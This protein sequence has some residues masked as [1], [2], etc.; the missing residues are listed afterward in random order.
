MNTYER[1]YLYVRG[2]SF[3][4]FSFCAWIVGQ[5]SPFFLL[6]YGILWKSIYMEMNIL[7]HLKSSNVDVQQRSS[8]LFI[9]NE[10]TIFRC[11]P[12]SVVSGGEKQMKIKRKRKRVRKRRNDRRRFD[13][14][15]IMWT[16]YKY[17]R[18]SV[19]HREESIDI[20]LELFGYN[21]I[22]LWS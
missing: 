3:S 1:I 19:T 9:V 8:Q 6:A 12:Y 5:H 14:T 22:Q 15:L 20:E 2:F 21:I 11:P 10:L 16:T 4:Y 7:I 13:T 18:H 17:G